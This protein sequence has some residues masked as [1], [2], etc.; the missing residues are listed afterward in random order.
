M[1]ATHLVPAVGDPPP[2]AAVAAAAEALRAGQ[3]VAVPTDTVYGVAA[4]PFSALATERLFAVKRRP[5]GVP[6]AVLV[7][8]VDQARLLVEEPTAPVAA[9]LARFWPGGLT[10]VLRRRAGA[11][12][13]LGDAGDTVGV[14]CPGHPVARAVAAAV[15]PIA[16]TSANRH[17]QPTPTTA[18][19]VA[20]ALG[21]EV[22]LVLDGGPCEG[23]PSTV[24][25][26]TGAR[27]ALLRAGAVAF[28]AVLAA[29]D[30]R[31]G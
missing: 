16:T 18:P 19:A 14:R 27:P 30:G 3:V 24:V 23:L 29:F 1:T 28:E 15:G 25:D 8:G 31:A 13:H 5:A 9:V 20:E 21:G 6:V 17:G 10:V 11:P 12:L 7:A 26:C 4:D 2:A 22:E